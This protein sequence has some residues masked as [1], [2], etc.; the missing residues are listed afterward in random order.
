MSL[1]IASVL[2]SAIIYNSSPTILKKIEPVKDKKEAFTIKVKGC[3]ANSLKLSFAKP[4]KLAEIKNKI[5]FKS[6]A[7]I[8]KINWNKIIDKNFELF[9]PSKTNTKSLIEWASLYSI[10]QLT[11]RGINKTIATKL[12]NLRREK[13]SNITWEDIFQIK[14]IGEKTLKKLQEIIKL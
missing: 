12:L 7:D 14:G 8:D 11:I 10:D 13:N 4:V 6:N 9:V 5:K 3:I 1:S 2:T